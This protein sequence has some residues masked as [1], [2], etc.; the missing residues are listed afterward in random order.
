[1]LYNIE[2]WTNLTKKELLKLESL[3]HKALCTLMHLPKTSPYLALLNELGLW[4]ME[5]R[6]MYRKIM[7]Y[8]NI[9]NS[10]DSRL[11]KNMIEEQEREREDGTWFMGVLSYLQILNIKLEVV[12]ESSKG[13]LKR[14]VK[15]RIHERMNRTMIAAKEKYKKMRFLNCDSFE[16]KKYI[17]FGGGNDALDALKTRLNMREIYGNYKGDFTLPRLCPYCEQ[18]EDTTE[19]LIECSVFGVTQLNETDLTNDE[20]I[21]LW[22]LINEKVAVNMKWRDG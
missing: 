13:V 9:I 17:K 8:H 7:L 1:M 14:I 10:A 22:K 12:R 19:H 6:L 21:K 11:V 20:N 16:L 2:G 18:E 5:E 15:E 4:K 3:Q